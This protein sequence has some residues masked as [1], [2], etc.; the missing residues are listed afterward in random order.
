MWLR[1]FNVRIGAPDKV[2]D[3]L[4]NKCSGSAFH[5]LR[6]LKHFHHFAPKKFIISD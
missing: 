2:N 5:A 4:S 3:R 6:V 1:Q